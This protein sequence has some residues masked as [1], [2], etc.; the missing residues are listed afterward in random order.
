VV[1]W[2]AAEGRELHGLIAHPSPSLAVALS[3][4]GRLLAG[5]GSDLTVKVWETQVSP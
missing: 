3:R 5:G 1:L 4:D 2:K